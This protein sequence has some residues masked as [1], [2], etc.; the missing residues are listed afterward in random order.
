MNNTPADTAVSTDF[1]SSA[2]LLENVGAPFIIGL[3]VG[4]FAKKIL[5]V[6]LFLGGAAIVLLFITEYYGITH[7]P[8]EQLQQAATAA[9]GFAQQS[10]SFLM[11]R[12]ANITSKGV[13]ATVGFAAGLK[14]G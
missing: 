6:A 3:A 4:F 1:L 7:V 11:D 12:L 9:T 8:D 2:F 10:G 14:L 13:S 5:K